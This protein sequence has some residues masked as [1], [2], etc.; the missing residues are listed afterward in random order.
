MNL[1]PQAN[2]DKPADIFAK[3]VLHHTMSR[4]SKQ[5]DCKIEDKIK[6]KMI[7]IPR[8]E[9]KWVNKPEIIPRGML[10]LKAL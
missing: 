2:T 5:S 7:L 10:I 9:Q 3:S 6:Q 4:H 8:T 1:T